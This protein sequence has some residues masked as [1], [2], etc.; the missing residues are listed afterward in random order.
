MKCPHC[1]NDTIAG[2]DDVSDMQTGTAYARCRTCGRHQLISKSGYVDW[3]VGLM[4]DSG[5]ALG[6]AWTQKPSAD[7][8]PVISKLTSA[9]SRRK[10]DR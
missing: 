7:V 2:W 5:A 10:R 4:L 3:R 8:L 1:P 9:I 6:S